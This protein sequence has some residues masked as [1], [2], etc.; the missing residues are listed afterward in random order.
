MDR[1]PPD[2]HSM[3]L[4]RMS[5]YFDDIKNLA[6]SATVVV[7]MKIVTQARGSFYRMSSYQNAGFDLSFS[8]EMA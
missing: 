2:N 8:G 4:T 5:Q 3:I 1:S 6:G 7:Q